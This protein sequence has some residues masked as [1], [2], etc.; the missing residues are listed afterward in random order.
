MRR[1]SRASHRHSATG[2]PSVVEGDLGSHLTLQCNVSRPHH[3]SQRFVWL[4]DGR[5]LGPELSWTEYK[6]RGDLVSSGL[7]LSDAGNYS[8]YLDTPHQHSSAQLIVRDPLL[9]TKR[10]F[11]GNCC[12][13][14]C[15]IFFLAP[16]GRLS[17]VTVHPSTVVATVRWHVSSD[18]GC[19]ISHFTL[20][21]QPTQQPPAN[22]S[23]AAHHYLPVHISPAARQFFVY[24]L[25]PGTPYMFRMW[26]SNRLGPGEAT[27]VYA[28]TSK[29]LDPA[30]VV[31]KMFAGGDDF[32]TAAWMVAVSMVMGTI[33]ILSCL[34]CLLIYKEGRHGAPICTASSS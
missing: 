5:G 9:P 34:S 17:N 10:L 27:T 28:S 30:E 26:A 29:P 23:A 6:Y 14:I 13:I 15:H 11:G 32:S 31:Q 18:G 3:Q 12:A 21:Y 24:H 33:L 1:D 19:P 2:L 25:E 20:A 8:C 16:P 22:S 7:L 4:K